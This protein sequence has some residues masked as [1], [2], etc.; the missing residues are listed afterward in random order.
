VPDAYVNGPDRSPHP[1]EHAGIIHLAEGH[2][3]APIGEFE[4]GL[5]CWALAGGHP[6]GEA[7]IGR[8]IGRA[9]A[10]LGHYDQATAHFQAALDTFTHLGEPYHRARTLLAIAQAYLAAAD[11]GAA[12]TALQQAIPLM[13]DQGHA[14]SL[15]E[16]LTTAAEA[17]AAVGNLQGARGHLGGALRTCQAAGIPAGHPAHARARAFAVSIGMLSPA[18]PGLAPQRGQQ[19]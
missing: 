5:R 11:P 9:H 8:Q 7:I 14:L 10:R 4:Y 15:A 6:R 12:I 16:I 2:P 1:H 17:H 18:H 3:G 13:E 19:P